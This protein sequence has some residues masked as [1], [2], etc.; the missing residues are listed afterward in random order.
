[1]RFL[2][3][4]DWGRVRPQAGRTLRLFGFRFWRKSGVSKVINDDVEAV[5]LVMA[6]GRANSDGAAFA[7]GG[8]DVEGDLLGFFCVVGH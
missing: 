4:G 5:A 7:V 6:E 8:E 3:V 1:M 2:E